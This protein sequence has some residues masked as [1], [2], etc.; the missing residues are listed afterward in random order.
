MRNSPDICSVDSQFAPVG[1]ES[2]MRQDFVLN[3]RLKVSRLQ[4]FKISRFLNSPPIFVD[5]SFTRS[6]LIRNDL[7]HSYLTGSNLI[8]SSSCSESSFLLSHMDVAIFNSFYDQYAVSNGSGYAVL[9]VCDEYAVLDRRT[10]YAVIQWKW[11]CLTLVEETECPCGTELAKAIIFE[12]RSEEMASFWSGVVAKL[13][14]VVAKM[15]EWCPRVLSGGQGSCL[16]L[17]GRIFNEQG[18]LFLDM[19]NV[20]SRKWLPF[21][22]TCKVLCDAVYTSY[23]RDEVH[24]IHGSISPEVSRLPF[25]CWWFD[26]GIPLGQ[27]ILGES[28]SSKFHFAVLGSN[29]VVRGSFVPTVLG[30]MTYPVTSLTLDSARSYVMQGAS[31]TQGTIPS[32]PIGGSISPEGTK[33]YQGSNSSDGGNT[34]DG[35]K[36]AGGVIGSYGGIESSEELKEVLPDVADEAEV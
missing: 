27:G 2:F 17:K 8:S 25:C 30:Q 28:T 11:I 31:F 7:V 33:K 1:V 9:N 3:S 32:I 6:A 26:I 19:P 29:L 18:R 13:L 10:G 12:C 16:G 5:I 35:V 15:L 21:T 14:G 20:L 4:H 34:G 24:Y 36:I 22:K 23:T